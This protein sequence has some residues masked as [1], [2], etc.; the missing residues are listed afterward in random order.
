VVQLHRPTRPLACCRV[1]YFLEL[2]PCRSCARVSLRDWLADEAETNCPQIEVPSETLHSKRIT[3][4]DLSVAP[5]SRNEG[6]VVTAA[7][8]ISWSPPCGKRTQR[9]CSRVRL[10]GGQA[11]VAYLQRSP[12]LRRIKSHDALWHC[13]A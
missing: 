6:V 10:G 4:S 3:K 12:N 9:S 13:R 1:A 2:F 8:R 7:P 11:R 5:G